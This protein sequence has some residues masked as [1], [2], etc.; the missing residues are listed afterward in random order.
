MVALGLCIAGMSILIA[1]LA[2]LGIP[3]GIMLAL[4]AAMSWAAG[5]A[6]HPQVS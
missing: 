5:T 3:T 6:P 4:A 2:G 1:P